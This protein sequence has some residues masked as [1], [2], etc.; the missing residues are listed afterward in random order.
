MLAL[1]AECCK[2]ESRLWLSCTDLCYAQA[3]RGYCP[4]GRGCDQSIG[5]TVSDAIVR[6]WS[7]STATMSS[8]LG[9]FSRLLPPLSGRT[10]SALVWH[11]EG[12]TFAAH[13]VQQVLWFAAQPVLQCAIRGAQGV[14]PCVECGVRPVNLIPSLTP[15]SVA[16]CGWL[17]LGAPHWA[18]SVNY[19]K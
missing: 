19:C 3:L 2:I 15:L 4:W 8:P 10:G 7:W 13:S 14:L 11:S 12:H 5:S 6:S 9:Y 18:T 17:K 1:H 16:D